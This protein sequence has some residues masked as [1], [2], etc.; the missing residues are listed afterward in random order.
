MGSKE[1]NMTNRSKLTLALA[2]LLATT[3]PVLADDLGSKVG[4]AFNS[5][6]K[7]LK[8]GVLDAYEGGTEGAKDVWAKTKTEANKVLGNNNSTSAP[9]SASPY[10]AVR[11]DLTVNVQTELNAAGYTAGPTDGIYGPRTADA[12][13]AYQGNNSLPQDGQVSLALLD[14]MRAK[15]AGQAGIA[16]TA[17]NAPACK[18]YQ[19]KLM[20]DGKEQVTQGTACLQPDGA[21]KPMN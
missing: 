17:A 20:V 10:P 5:A 11:D 16:P 19:T 9:A 2:M 13:R 6:Y 14:H 21:W 7:G 4:G 8:E 1:K 12:I 15:R 18:P 3:A